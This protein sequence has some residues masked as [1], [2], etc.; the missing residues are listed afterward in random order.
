MNKHWSLTTQDDVAIL[1]LRREDSEMNVF[2]EDVLREMHSNIEE[3]VKESQVKGLVFVV[4]VALTFIGIWYYK[5]RIREKRAEKM[6]LRKNGE[7]T[8]P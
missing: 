8:V 2:S 1:T 7:N 6:L 3:I 4:L 5:K